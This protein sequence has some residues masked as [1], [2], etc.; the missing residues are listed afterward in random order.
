MCANTRSMQPLLWEGY[1]SLQPLDIPIQVWEDISMD[2]I[3]GLPK[4]RGYEAVLVVVDRLS[5]YGH[6]VLLRHPYTAKSVAELF[7]K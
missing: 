2:F 7:I 6:F 3:T 5:K 1:S 4:S